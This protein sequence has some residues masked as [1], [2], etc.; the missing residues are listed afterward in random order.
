MGKNNIVFYIR[1]LFRESILPGREGIRKPV[2]I[3]IDAFKNFAKISCEDYRSKI[4]DIQIKNLI[5]ISDRIIINRAQDSNR[6]YNYTYGILQ[7]DTVEKLKK[8]NDDDIIIPLDDDD[9]LD[10]EI[11]N[12]NLDKEKIN[13]WNTISFSVNGVHYHVENE[14][15][16]YDR[17]LDDI[18]VI[19]ARGLL[20]N[21]QALPAFLVKRLLYS[22]KFEDR[23]LAQKLLQRHTQPRLLIREH[24]LNEYNIREKIFNNLLA[25]YVKH[26]ANITLFEAQNIPNNNINYEQYLSIVEPYKKFNYLNIKNFPENYNWCI[27]Y[28]IEL[29]EINKLL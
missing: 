22:N 18:Q 15:L 27:P 5:T 29:Q 4:H 6:E 10:P 8:L 3:L 25:V 9:W 28:L 12:L 16:P 26:A 14:E 7:D 19:K 1:A 21:C 2:G 11:K 24:P 20:S 17:P 13:C 23:L